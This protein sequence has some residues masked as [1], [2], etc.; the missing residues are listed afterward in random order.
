[1]T[2]AATR[3]RDDRR[4][5]AKKSMVMLRIQKQELLLP[6]MK[7]SLRFRMRIA[8]EI[9]S[10]RARRGPLKGTQVSTATLRSFDAH[11]Q[12]KG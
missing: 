7:T 8:T 12:N 11:N 9:S 10:V 3:C 1:M 2:Q 5:L 6:T 4:L